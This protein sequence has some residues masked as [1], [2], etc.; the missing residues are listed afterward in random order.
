[1]KNKYRKSG[2]GY[3]LATTLISVTIASCSTEPVGPPNPPIASRA[4]AHH[5]YTQPG[6]KFSPL[7]LL[8]PFV[9]DNESSYA[10]GM[11]TLTDST[12]H[13][14]FYVGPSEIDT[15]ELDFTPTSAIINSQVCFYT[16]STIITLPSGAQVESEWHNPWGIPI[17]DYG[18]QN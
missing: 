18:Q 3:F 8:Q 14:N 12:E 4:L 11:V 16:D 15:A 7:S 10:L 13:F 9:I 17:I 2:L 6:A 5:V 1:M